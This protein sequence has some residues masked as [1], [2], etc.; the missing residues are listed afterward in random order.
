[1]NSEHIYETHPGAVILQIFE[2][3]CWI[4]T[5]DAS[6]PRWTLYGDGTLLF[7]KN[8]LKFEFLQAHLSLEEMQQLLTMVIDQKQIFAS[9]RENYPNS[10]VMDANRWIIQIKVD[11]RYLIV[12]TCQDSSDGPEEQRLEE[13]VRYLLS[14]ACSLTTTQVYQVTAVAL[15]I[16]D[17]NIN[18]NAK[19]M[20]EPWPY[21]QISLAKLAH[22]VLQIE[23]N[24]MFPR[25]SS[26]S[27]CL[28][29]QD[30]FPNFTQILFSSRMIGSIVGVSTLYC[31]MRFIP[32]LGKVL[33][34]R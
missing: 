26:C 17:L 16:M 20:A 24:G 29:Y 5:Y 9:T 3:G 25:N 12:K 33:P 22:L 6:I 18:P 7:S 30:S 34:I 31:R 2:S 27:R 19:R 23:E 14:F 15:D 13:I 1:L 11:E 32:Y 4:T 28:L 21:S 10:H 8:S